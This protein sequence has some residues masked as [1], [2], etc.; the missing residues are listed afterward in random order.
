MSCQRPEVVSVPMSDTVTIRPATHE[1]ADFL[2]S[3]RNE[4]AVAAASRNTQLVDEES[5]LEWLGSSLASSVRRLFIVCADG[6]PIGQARLDIANDGEW[7]SIAFV[8]GQRGHGHG[9]KVL[10]TLQRLAHGDLLAE[11]KSGNSSSLALF[12][13]AG[14][15]DWV[16]VDG[17]AQLKWTYA[18]D[19]IAARTSEVR[20]GEHAD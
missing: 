20:V 19:L 18:P 4:P 9:T 16:S 1:D 5:H 17:F 11:I 10:R 6:K 14:F 2:R 8:D 13:R 7:V 3:V 12:H 15:E